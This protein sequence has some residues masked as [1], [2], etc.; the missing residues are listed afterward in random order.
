MM[1]MLTPRVL[2]AVARVPFVC[3]RKVPF[4]DSIFGNEQQATIAFKV[5]KKNAFTTPPK[6]PIFVSSEQT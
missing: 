6:R 2:V 1:M 5:G 3:K 4:Y